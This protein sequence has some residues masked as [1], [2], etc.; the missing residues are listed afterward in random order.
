M[1]Q[2]KAEIRIRKFVETDLK[3]VMDIE[4]LLRDDG[5]KQIWP[6]SFESYWE[7][8]NPN[9][10]FVAELD[11]DVVGFVVGKIV[12]RENKKSVFQSLHTGEPYLSNEKVGFVDMI[13]IRPKHHNKGI[14]KMLMEA[15]YQEC[16]SHNAVMRSVVYDNDERFKSFLT[17]MGFKESNA[18]IYER[19]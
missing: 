7:I 11:G 6:F 19:V 12:K 13:G 5:Q 1:I 9:V 10:S 18:V 4:Q 16:K 17:S 14:G 3:L 8:Y 2:E 15:F